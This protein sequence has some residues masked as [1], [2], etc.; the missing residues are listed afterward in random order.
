MDA[1]GVAGMIGGTR[2]EEQGAGV[3]AKTTRVL[4]GVTGVALSTGGGPRMTCDGGK[5]VS[6]LRVCRWPTMNGAK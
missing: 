5:R 1:A 4:E 6:H 3:A 2:R